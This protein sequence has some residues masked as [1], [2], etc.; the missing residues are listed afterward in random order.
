MVTSK[1]AQ[2]YNRSTNGSDPGKVRNACGTDGEHCEE[3][4]EMTWRTRAG[5]P[6]EGGR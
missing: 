6:I 2:P 3:L 5:G 4:L 1:K